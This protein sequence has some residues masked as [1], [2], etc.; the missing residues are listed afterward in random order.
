[1]GL[2]SI[3]AVI[4]DVD[5]VLTDGSIV[6][7][8][9]GASGLTELKAF[10][11]ADGA[12]IVWL[13]ECSI[14]VAFLTGRKSEV[15]AFRAKELGVRHVRQGASP[16]EGAYESLLA[17]LG[18]TDGETCYIGDDLADV[19]VMRRAGY[20]VAVANARPEVQGIAD[21]VTHARGGRGAV[22]EVAERILKA[23]G[24]WAAIVARYGL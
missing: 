17:E 21:Y 10:N 18:T 20:G 6:L 15:V 19:P 2:E 9:G 12:G 23:Q 22:R 1:M 3:R 14:E 13:R 4:C 5:G 24:K 16:K 8:W 7:G 11:V